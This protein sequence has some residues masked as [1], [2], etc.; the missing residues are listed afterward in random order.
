MFQ[1]LTL[2][3]RLPEGTRSPDEAWALFERVKM[4]TS[5]TKDREQ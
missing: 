5:S 2:L 1:R 4:H 3:R